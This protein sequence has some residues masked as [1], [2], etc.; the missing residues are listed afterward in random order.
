MRFLSANQ[1]I[2]F[3]SAKIQ[4]FSD[5][6]KNISFTETKRGPGGPLLLWSWAD[7]WHAVGSVDNCCL[8]GQQPRPGGEFVPVVLF[9]Q[10][11]YV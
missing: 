11:S 2:G 6:T 3:A 9:Q 1:P 7:S 8:L 10:G 4:T 5:L